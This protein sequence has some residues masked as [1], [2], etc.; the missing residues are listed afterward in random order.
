MKVKKTAAFILI[1]TLLLSLFPAVFATGDTLTREFTD[2]LGRTVILPEKVERIALSGTLA[3]LYVMP[4]CQEKL[5][6]YASQFSKDAESFFPK[7]VTSLPYLGRL[8]DGNGGTMDAESLLSVNPDVIIDIGEAKKNMAEDFDK[9]SEITGI[10]YVHINATVQ[11]A[12]NAYLRLGE[13][14]GDIA[15]ARKLSDWCEETYS[16]VCSIMNKV[17]ADNVRKSIL[18]CL[19]NDGLNV[20]AEKSFHAMSINIVSDN[21][22]KIENP[23][24]SNLGNTVSF[25]QIMLWDPEVIIFGTQ[26]AYETATKTNQD[27]WKHLKSIQSGNYYMMPSIPYGWLSA[28]P[29]VQHYL[30]LIWLCSILYPDYCTYNLEEKVTE[31]YSLFYSYNLSHEEYKKILAGNWY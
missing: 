9:Y 4:L 6:G 13:L 29:S 23:V 21:A 10:P 28:P 5:V 16:E 7:S 31:F 11:T 25:E 24:S 1:I 18:F 19:G 8:Y 20:I 26:Q 12:A 17:D 2:D 22:A 30:G 15:K 3:Q 14:T 27:V